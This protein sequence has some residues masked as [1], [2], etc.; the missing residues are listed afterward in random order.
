MAEEILEKNEWPEE[1]LDQFSQRLV[2]KVSILVDRALELLQDLYKSKV[3]SNGVL[4]K[5]NDEFMHHKKCT[6]YESSEDY[7]ICCQPYSVPVTSEIKALMTPEL[8]QWNDL[9]NEI[10]K[11]TFYIECLEYV[12][13]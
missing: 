10:D 11:V 5:L 7:N 9:N 3:I 13:F 4:I 12:G 1:V 8:D 2:Q 6:Y